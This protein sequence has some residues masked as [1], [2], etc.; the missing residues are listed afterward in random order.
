MILLLFSLSW[1]VVLNLSHLKSSRLMTPNFEL[2]YSLAD[3][4]IHK[5][6]K[7]CRL[8][9]T[10]RWIDTGWVEKHFFYCLHCKKVFSRTGFIT[11]ISPSPSLHKKSKCFWPTSFQT[12]Q[13]TTSFSSVN[14]NG[15]LKTE[16]CVVW[17][18]LNQHCHKQSLSHPNISRH[19]GLLQ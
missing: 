5:L 19:N 7:N 11:T 16:R 18:M 15:G 3:L 10:V 6:V 13:D 8:R 9:I 4:K 1:L 14:L 17:H 2:K 12:R